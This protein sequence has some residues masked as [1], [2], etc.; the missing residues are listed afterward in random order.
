MQIQSLHYTIY[1]CVSAGRTTLWLGT[2]TVL[3]P[4]DCVTCGPA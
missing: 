1:D 4:E 2:A 3:K